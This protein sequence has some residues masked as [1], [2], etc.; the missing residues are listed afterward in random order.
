MRSYNFYVYIMASQKNGT[1]YVGVT[2]NLERRA[3]EHKHGFNKGFT[4]KYKCTKL[5]Y[6]EHFQDVYYAIAREKQLKGGS[7]KSKIR[8]IELENP[9]WQDLSLQ[10]E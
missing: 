4:K 7:R 2:N 3:W 5:V 9:G 1:L 8:L 10:W 6:Y